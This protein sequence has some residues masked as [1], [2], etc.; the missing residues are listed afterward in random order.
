M[1]T[2]QTYRYGTWSGTDQTYRYGTWSGTDHTYR[3]GTWS[4]TDVMTKRK[5]KMMF[6]EEC[7]VLI[8]I[9]RQEKSYTLHAKELK[10]DVAQTN[11]GY[12][13]V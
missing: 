10:V 8:K 5:Q 9:L 12:S 1:T 13:R 3:Y 7:R 11:A 6:S 2:D 4:R